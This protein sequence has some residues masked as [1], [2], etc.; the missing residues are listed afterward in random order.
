MD[1]HIKKILIIRFSSIGDIVLTTPVVRCIKKQFPD[2]IIHYLTKPAFKEIL[3]NNPYINKVHL[4]DKHPACK[5]IELKNENYDFVIDLHHNLRTIIFKTILDIPSSA[6]PKLNIEKFLLVNF[7][8][9]LMPQKHI[10][11]RYFKA[12]EVLKVY[13]DGEGL[14]YFIPEIDR[15][16]EIKGIR[17][18]NTRY[19]TWAIGAQ[20]FTKRLP[21]D[22]IIE[23]C[24]K[25]D[26]LVILLGGKDDTK[27]GD[28]IAKDIGTQ[29]INACGLL[30]LNQSAW[31]IKNSLR[32]YTNDTGLMHIAAALK[33][34]IT[35][36]WGNT[37]PAFGM[38]PY[39]GSEPIENSII[40]NNNLPCRPCSKI[41][42][43]HC[44]RKH[45]KCM[46]NLPVVSLSDN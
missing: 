20:H 14:D 36:F 32:L 18:N 27:N 38:Y 30:S 17:L 42:Y 16:S 35:S 13:H 6:Y 12:T 9:N 26:T 2:V 1:Q 10:V 25:S 28:E 24:K 45:F 34:P 41:G 40:E 23:S 43:D 11:D 39:Y 29:C 5:A 4:L 7:K 21:N 31:V 8:I 15:L 37:V 22:K 44:P 33:K 3:A 19:I 46:K